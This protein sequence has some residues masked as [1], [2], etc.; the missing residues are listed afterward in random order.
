M[1]AGGVLAIARGATHRAGI[2]WLALVALAAAT[3]GMAI[4]ALRLSAIDGGAFDGPTG[5]DVKVTGYVTAVP[6]RANGDVTVRISTAAGRL[7]LEATSRCRTSRSAARCA[8]AMLAQPRPGGGLP[9][10][11]RHSP[12]APPGPSHRRASAAPASRVPWTASGR[13]AAALESGTPD[14]GR[15][16]R[17]FLLGEDDRI[18]P[19]TV[20]IQARRAPHYQVS[21]VAML[22]RCSGHGCSGSRA[23]HCARDWSP[24]WH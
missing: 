24:C 5:R 23:P 9:G 12:G 7:A 13:A 4:G 21:G 17:R 11:I 20:G 16:L 3:G 1:I 2:A 15:H 22:S 18:D 8:R 10:A 14:A 6:H 19:A